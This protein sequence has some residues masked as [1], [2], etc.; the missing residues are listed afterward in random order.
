MKFSHVKWKD[1]QS[2]LAN[3]LHLK[4]C[5]IRNIWSL[6]L[7]R[8]F[9]SMC[10]CSY[11][12][13]YD[14]YSGITT[15]T[16]FNLCEEDEGEYTC[17]AINSLGESS[18]SATLLSPGLVNVWFSSWVGCGGMTCRKLI[19]FVLTVGLSLTIL[20]KNGWCNLPRLPFWKINN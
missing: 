3:A 1:G 7:Y 9:L 4:I 16:I 5:L 11:K 13:T 10:Y 18:T 15:L 20:K 8:L 2:C 6:R 19:T 14:Q 17:K 12:S